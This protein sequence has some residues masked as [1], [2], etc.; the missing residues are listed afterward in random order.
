[1]EVA[2]TSA[3]Q[4]TGALILATSALLLVWTRRLVSKAAL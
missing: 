1:M 4:V 2:F 3:H